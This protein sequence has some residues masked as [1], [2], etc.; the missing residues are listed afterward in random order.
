MWLLRIMSFRCGELVGRVSQLCGWV[1]LP[2]VTTFL[3]KKQTMTSLWRH[4]MVLWPLFMENVVFFSEFRSLKCWNVTVEYWKQFQW[5]VAW[6]FR[7]SCFFL[8]FFNCFKDQD[9][10]FFLVIFRF[11][12][13]TFL[14][15]VHPAIQVSFCICILFQIRPSHQNCW[16]FGIE[17]TSSPSISCTV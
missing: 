5:N 4:L 1:S 9:G 7:Y 2:N 6:N 3:K 10:W 15:H 17:S 16:I 13:L 11:F 8:R 12:E 14:L